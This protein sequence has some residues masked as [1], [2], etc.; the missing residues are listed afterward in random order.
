VASAAS[1]RSSGEL[2]SRPPT[3]RTGRPSPRSCSTPPAPDG[4]DGQAQ[5]AQLLDAGLCRHGV[6]GGEQRAVDQ[7][8]EPLRA[9]QR[10]GLRLEQAIRHLE[11]R[12]VHARSGQRGHQ[13]ARD[14][15]DLAR[16]HPV[17]GREARVG[18]VER[19]RGARVGG[20]PHVAAGAGSRE[21]RV[22]R[23]QAEPQQAAQQVCRQRALAHVHRRAEHGDGARAIGAERGAR[24]QRPVRQVDGP[25]GGVGD[26]AEG[27]DGRGSAADARVPRN[28]SC[29]DAAARHQ[30]A[31]LEPRRHERLEL[32]ARVA[33]SVG[34]DDL[35]A[36]EEVSPLARGQVE[37]AVVAQ[38]LDARQHQIPRARRRIRREPEHRRRVHP[39][40]DERARRALDLFC[41]DVDRIHALSSSGA[42]GAPPLSP[43]TRARWRCRRFRS[44]RLCPWPAPR[45]PPEPARRIRRKK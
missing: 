14:A 10:R 32:A 9:H 1:R 28:R 20:K 26:Q 33:R 2:V 39:A 29:R 38:A 27:R 6:G 31:R 41:I 42:R 18:E 24:G 25:A 11:H 5:P 44:R 19:G 17:G 16:R 40:R 22:A 21:L 15:L 23:V 45:R 34:H 3:A 12:H 37:P 43:R 36:L 4:E 35:V 7:A 30:V 8:R 13:R